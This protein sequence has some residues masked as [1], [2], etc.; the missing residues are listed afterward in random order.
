MNG[1]SELIRATHHSE[2]LILNI[3]SLFSCQYT[4]FPCCL[5]HNQCLL[6]CTCSAPSCHCQS[7]CSLCIL[8]CFQ[9]PASCTRVISA[10]LTLLQWPGW[11][12]LRAL[13]L[14]RT[15]AEFVCGRLSQRPACCDER[16]LDL[17]IHFT[18]APINYST[19]Q[20][21][22]NE[23]ER[24]GP[25]PPKAAT[26]QLSPWIIGAINLALS[27]K[28]VLTLLSLSLFVCFPLCTLQ[29]PS[30]QQSL[31]THIT[32]THTHTAAVIIA[33]H[34]GT[35]VQHAGEA[36]SAKCNLPFVSF[37]AIESLWNGIKS[38]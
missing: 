33:E 1:E 37:V 36:R 15:A 4:L 12:Q 29:K 22:K 18:F 16:H 20:P 38:F 27:N 30:P 24:S 21:I 7:P 35:I 34:S 25:R 28:E 5:Q 17:P 19:G 3:A 6:H 32:T 23:G 26:R 8:L 9:R 14:L 2:S 13:C 10:I 11:I 31:Q